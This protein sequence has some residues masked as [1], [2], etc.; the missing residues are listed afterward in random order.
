MKISQFLTPEAISLDVKGESISEA[1]SELAQ[2]IC[3]GNASLTAKKVEELL[4][5]REQM[6]CT[7]SGLGL[8]FPHCY[9]RV[10]KPLFAL[11]IHRQGIEADSPD[12]QP[13]QILLTVISPED[14][15]ELHL[16]ALSSASKLFLKETVREQVL[17]ADSAEKILTILS[18]HEEA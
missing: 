18:E 9:C 7:A 3:S 10:N 17:A 15:P 16:D 2:L 8:A 14:R 1:S 5:E 4:I 11:G 13:V 6:L 12:K